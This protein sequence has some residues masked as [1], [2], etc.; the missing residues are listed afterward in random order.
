MSH[1]GWLWRPLS[2]FILVILLSLPLNRLPSPWSSW[3]RD[4]CEIT[5]CYC[6]PVRE[7]LILQPLSTYSNLAFVLAGLI[8][9][10]APHNPSATSNAMLSRPV[11]A[12]V[13]GASI[14]GTGAGSFF[15]HASLTRAGEWFDL[16]ATYL[17]LSFVLLYNAARLRP[18]PGLTFAGVYLALN[19]A[20]GVQMVVAREL[21]Q[22]VFG[23]LAASALGAEGLVWFRRDR[24][25][26]VGYLTAALACFGVG[27]ALWVTPC[28]TGLPIPSHALWHVLSAAAMLLLFEYY[29]SE[30]S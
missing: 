9:L 12:R 13:L 17:Y 26:Q 18:V 30:R 10:A 11:F 20:G 29:R 23:G 1:H 16:V 28:M 21:Q 3:I 24:T 15:Y 7:S 27:A 2:I 14:I 19:L 22:V 8:V 25:A 4:G 6:E 5:N